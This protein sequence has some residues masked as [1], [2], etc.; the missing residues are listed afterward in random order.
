MYL[1]STFIFVFIGLLI[2]KFLTKLL[3]SILGIYAI[4][5]NVINELQLYKL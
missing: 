2:N 3:D 1:H 4:L 5:K